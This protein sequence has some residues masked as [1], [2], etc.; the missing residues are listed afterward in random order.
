[1]QKYSQY[2]LPATSSFLFYLTRVPF[3]VLTACLLGRPSLELCKS[4]VMLRDINIS[5]KIG[6]GDI[7]VLMHMLQFWRVSFRGI[8]TDVTPR[9]RRAKRFT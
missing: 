5:G 6:L 7:P 9:A 4:L 3:Y 8:W 2:S 1:M